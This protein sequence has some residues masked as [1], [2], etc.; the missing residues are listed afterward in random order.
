MADTKSN[1]VP[2][3]PAK[4][5]EA[6]SAV[7]PKEK[8]ALKT[9]EAES[10]F[11]ARLRITGD[12]PRVTIVDPPAPPDPYIPYYKHIADAR[13]IAASTNANK[14]PKEIEAA[15]NV[16]E[17]QA[18]KDWKGPVPPVDTKAEKAKADAEKKAAEE[19]AAVAVELERL[20]SLV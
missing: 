1:V 13:A 14:S 16:A 10:E 11:V 12:P 20:E 9:T 3:V 7:S 8:P 17:A 15:Q 5:A 6:K 2:V 4:P 18:K 19:K